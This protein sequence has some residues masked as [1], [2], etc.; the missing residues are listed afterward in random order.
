ILQLRKNSPSSAHEADRFWKT[1]TDLPAVR[2]GR[3]Y[4]V[5]SLTA[6][7]PGFSIVATAEIFANALHPETAPPVAARAPGTTTA[8]RAVVQGADDTGTSSTLPAATAAP[9]DSSTQP[10]SRARQ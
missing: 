2:D 5:T 1:V 3:V 9:G 7:Q 4:P 10:N 6:M 8:D